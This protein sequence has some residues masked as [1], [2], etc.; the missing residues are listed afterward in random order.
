MNLKVVV[1]A[2][3]AAIFSLS[4]TKN[5]DLAKPVINEL[6][7]G[8]DNSHTG[9][10]GGGLHVEAEVTA[11][12]KISKIEV[13]IHQEDNSRAWASD[14]VYTEFAG[15]KNTMFHKHI[16][17]PLTAAAGTYCFHFT[18]TDEDGQQTSVEIEDLTIQASAD[19]AGTHTAE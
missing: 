16:D 3:A 18:V 10:I 5:N 19:T 14:S 15:L 17:I 11:E 12:A 2:C 1:T 9:S 6:Q 7:L 4:C 8:L 13:L